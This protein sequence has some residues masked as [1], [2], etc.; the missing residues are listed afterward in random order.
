MERVPLAATLQTRQRGAPS[1]SLLPL[2]P[3][4]DVPPHVETIDM[5]WAPSHGTERRQ[6]PERASHT[7]SWKSWAEDSTIAQPCSGAY[8]GAE[9]ACT[10]STAPRWPASIA[11]GPPASSAA[12]YTPILPSAM[13]AQRSSSGASGRPTRSEPHGLS[14]RTSARAC[15]AEGEET[16]CSSAPLVDA[17]AQRNPAWLTDPPAPA[18]QSRPVAPP[19]TEHTASVLGAAASR[20]TRTTSGAARP[21]GA[22]E[23]GPEGAME[24]GPGGG[25][26]GERRGAE[27]EWERKKR[28]EREKERRGETR[29]GEE[30]RRQRQ[31][32]YDKREE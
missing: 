24:K 30:R 7:R 11:L 31:R 4:P 29:R 20:A 16:L 1:P 18:V 22:M 8:G 27:R 5:T 26:D 6:S 28:R 19:A 10:H 14:V 17:L 25:A 2:V 32:W 3:T 15:T 23:E 9:G 12:P 13:P 21:E